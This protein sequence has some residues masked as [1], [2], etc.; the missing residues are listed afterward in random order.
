MHEKKRKQAL[1]KGSK[2]QESF[3]Q[4]Q[5]DKNLF[6]LQVRITRF[7]HRQALKLKKKRGG[8]ISDIYEAAILSAST[9]DAPAMHEPSFK[10]EDLG[11]KSICPWVREG[12]TEHFEELATN[13][14]STVTAMSAALYQYCKRELDE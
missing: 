12:T 13:Y 7:A 3:R 6:P 4:R 2:R 11:V 5:R 1:M 8:K 14:R 10:E 9:T